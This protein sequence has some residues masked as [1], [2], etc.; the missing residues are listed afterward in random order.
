MGE[1]YVRRVHSE[2]AVL[3]IGQ[4]LG[5][6]VIYTRAELCGKQ[7]DVSLKS[8]DWIKTHT[9]VLERRSNGKAVY[10]AL[11]AALAAGDYHIW[12]N[13][14]QPFGEVSIEEG[15][16]IELWWS[17]ITSPC[18]TSSTQSPERD[19]MSQE[20]LPCY[21]SGKKISAAAMSSAPMR[22]TS[23]GQVAWNE[24]WGDFCDLALAGGPPHRGILLE[25]AM[26]EAVRAEAVAYEGIV[27]EIERGIRLVS[28][29]STVRSES[30]GWVGIKCQSEEMAL[31]LLRAIIVENICARREGDVLYLPAGP[32]FQLEKEI[33]NVVT[34]V[35]KT[36]HYWTEHIAA[37]ANESE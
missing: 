9:D 17:N 14:S 23:D 36:H 31:W 8:Y 35:A 30:P 3:D 27:A 4:D 24:M 25:P 15:K 13:G 12:G 6:L 7:I 10:A 19:S 16:V 21:Q 37:T 18:F 28:S 1:R 11:F 32:Y 26:P 20:V 22:Y 5:A 2:H 29:L 34:V 33:K